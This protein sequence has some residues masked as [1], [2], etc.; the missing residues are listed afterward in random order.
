M[1]KTI[2]F[3]TK[4][5]AMDEKSW[6]VIRDWAYAQLKKKKIKTIGV[7]EDVRLMPWSS[8]YRVKTD[9]GFFYLKYVQ[10]QGC[11]EAPLLQL[12]ESRF[13]GMVPSL[14]SYNKELSCFILRDAGEMLRICLMRDGYN[15]DHV[16][17]VFDRYCVIQRTLESDANLLIN[18]NIPDWRL[19]NFT[20]RYK[21]FIEDRCFIADLG[22]DEQSYKT[23]ISLTPSVHRLC[24]DIER[25]G[26]PETLEHADFQDNNIL[27]RDGHFFIS[28]WGDAVISHPF[29][30]LAS[31]IR[32]A[33][34]NHSISALIKGELEQ[35]YLQHWLDRFDE[36]D[37]KSV[38]SRIL[39]LQ[40]IKWVM[41]FYHATLES[42]PAA[43]LPF[44]TALLKSVLDFRG[45]FN[46][47]RDA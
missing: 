8:V 33:E 43:Y 26:V 11:Y 37:L 31:F 42:G 20:N 41:N 7:F 3:R 6:L 36:H 1:L 25:V 22:V 44:K 39:A 29:F 13:E 32:S 46:D 4:G 34:R 28:D 5:F 24:E 40:D 30:S 14:L 16:K 47:I 2:S 15:I 38:Y 19:R 10:G 23:L 45:F 35:A 18:L 17:K 27:V 12:L 21:N 9:Q